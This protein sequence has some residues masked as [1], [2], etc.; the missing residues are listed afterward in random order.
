MADLLART[1]DIYQ[2]M[3]ISDIRKFYA[4][5]MAPGLSLRRSTNQLSFMV[6]QFMTNQLRGNCIRTR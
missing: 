1:L 4:K 6:D 5:L 2:F 3:I